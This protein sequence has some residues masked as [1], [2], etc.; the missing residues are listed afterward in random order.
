MG[1][2]VE[3]RRK[4]V[5]RGSGQWLSEDLTR[6]NPFAFVSAIN[7]AMPGSGSG[8][9]KLTR[10]V[11]LFSLNILILWP[12][13][14]E[15]VDSMTVESTTRTFQRGRQN[16]L[17]ERGRM[18]Q[19]RVSRFRLHSRSV[20]CHHFGSA[21]SADVFRQPDNFYFEL[22]FPPNFCVFY[23]NQIHQYVVA[24][25]SALDL[26]HYANSSVSKGIGKVIVSVPKFTSE[27]S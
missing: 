26:E 18:P 25:A 14:L 20:H 16:S 21:P 3:R 11:N 19:D 24:P 23:H 7:L 6:A 27:L 9:T 12:R 13:S 10:C 2:L 15:N 17:G 22:P 4:D 8:L 5:R 1:E